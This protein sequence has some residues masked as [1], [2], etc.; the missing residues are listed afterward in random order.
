MSSR[1][2][3]LSW[4][5][6]TPKA[7]NS[8]S[9]ISALE[10]AGENLVNYTWL[11]AKHNCQGQKTPWNTFFEILRLRRPN[12]SKDTL[13]AHLLQTPWGHGQNYSN[14]KVTS[15]YWLD[16]QMDQLIHWNQTLNKSVNRRLLK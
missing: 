8:T 3:T 4:A 11:K 14:K 2:I 15:Q 10:E 1:F 13:L 7:Q 5:L 12:H 9:G 16:K 6:I